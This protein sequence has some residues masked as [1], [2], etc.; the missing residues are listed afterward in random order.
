MKSVLF[1]VCGAIF[2]FLLHQAR[3]TD[4]DTIVSMFRFQD[5]HLAGVMGVA[6]AVAA[7]G[8]W[9]LRRVGPRPI[10]G[11]QPE[12]QHKPMQ[13]GMFAAGL[14][15]GSGWALTGA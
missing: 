8:L 10:V 3:A 11:G 2:G 12:L 13:P 7:L 6:I 1:L 15:F 5:L 4:Y 14:V 9:I